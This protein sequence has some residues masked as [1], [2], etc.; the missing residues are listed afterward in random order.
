MT[1]LRTGIGLNATIL[2]LA[3]CGASAGEPSSD[4]DATAA[5]QADAAPP[6][7]DDP[8][9]AP[10]ESTC[11]PP[12]L[13]IVLDRSGSF[14]RRPNGTLP[15]NTNAGK[16]ETRWHIAVTAIES[17]TAALEDGLQ[18]GLA[19]FPY[20]PDCAGGLDCSN[21][22]TGSRSTCRRSRTISPASRVSSRSRRR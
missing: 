20:D 2:F 12:H 7:P 10:S 8:D 19:M 14:A 5:G 16:R 22:D 9:A 11:R 4:P 15:P 17:V 13:M 3:A 21:L 6:S 1:V 18:F